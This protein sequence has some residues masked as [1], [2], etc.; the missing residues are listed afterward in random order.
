MRV[1]L[2]Q[3]PLE[4]LRQL[5]DEY[6]IQEFEARLSDLY[7]LRG[8]TYLDN[9]L[10][11]N[12]LCQYLNSAAMHEH[13]IA[14]RGHTGDDR[15]AAILLRLAMTLIHMHRI[16]EAKEVYAEAL[17]RAPGSPG[18]LQNAAE[19]ILRYGRRPEIERMLS[20]FDGSPDAPALM[21]SLQNTAE[22]F[23]QLV[24]ST[25]LQIQ[26]TSDGSGRRALA[27]T[28][29][30]W[31][32][33][34]ASSFV[35]FAFPMMMAPGN[36][37][38]LAQAFRLSVC[39]FTT[40][41]DEAILRTSPLFEH[42]ERI[43]S[44]EF[45]YFD[46]SLGEVANEPIARY[47]LL[48]LPHYVAL[49]AGRRTG[50][51]VAFAFPDNIIND[52]FYATIARKLSAGASA[53]C[54]AGFRVT[55]SDILP[56]IRKRK[57]GRIGE[58]AIPPA[59]TAR[60]LMTHLSDRWYHDSKDITGRPFVLCWRKGTSGIHVRATH[61]QPFAIDCER[62]TK[63]LFPSIDNIDGQF[64][65]WNFDNYRDIALVNDS[66]MCVIDAGQ[67]AVHDQSAPGK[68]QCFDVVRFARFFQIYDCEINRLFLRTPVNLDVVPNAAKSF[69]EASGRLVEDVLALCDT[70]QTL[71]PPRPFWVTADERSMKSGEEERADGSV[72]V[73]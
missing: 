37:P 7:L 62:L 60:L 36:I 19:Y 64:L 5:I 58:L 55:A 12:A 10:V 32:R 38:F 52:G 65:E 14:A 13:W 9:G 6:G 68:E 56:D 50:A 20:G 28:I 39:I 59:E 27:L 45:R 22:A 24:Q 46:E 67:R 47:L 26:R 72:A 66:D 71:A 29:P 73:L 8:D 70:F 11:E 40:K 23:E 53:V 30:V 35:D 54:C 48:N 43:A 31:G 57:R 15:A 4:F 25:I 51:H 21:T 3:E 18:V 1:E 41:D 44:V 42:L 63:R 61:F 2:R 69:D 17:R 49:E 34:Y 16:P 33:G